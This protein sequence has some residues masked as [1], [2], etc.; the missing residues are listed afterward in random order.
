MPQNLALIDEFTLEETMYF[1]AKLNNIDMT[2]FEQ[3]KDF[4]INF[5]EL[6]KDNRTVSTFS[7]QFFILFFAVLLRHILPFLFVLF[8]FWLLQFMFCLRTCMSHHAIYLHVCQHACWCI[9][10]HVSGSDK[11]EPHDLLHAL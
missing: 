3:R 2:D 4:L 9:R 11:C 6:P 5:L 8:A 10:M 1:Y 7:G